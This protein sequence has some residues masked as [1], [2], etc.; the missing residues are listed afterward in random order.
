MVSIQFRVYL[1]MDLEISRQIFICY[2]ILSKDRPG[3]L[4]KIEVAILGNWCGIAAWLN[5]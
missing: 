4:L 1:L 5:F 2:P 3:F